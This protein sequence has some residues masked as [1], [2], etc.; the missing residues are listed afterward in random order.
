MSLLFRAMISLRISN[1]TLVDSR[2]SFSL[3]VYCLMSSWAVFHSDAMV[4]TSSLMVLMPST[5]SSPI[6]FAVIRDSAIAIEFALKNSA[7]A[8]SSAADKVEPERKSHTFPNG[9]DMNPPRFL[10]QVSM[11]RLFF[12]MISSTFASDFANSSIVAPPSLSL[13]ISS[14]ACCVRSM[15]PFHLS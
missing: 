8:L 9:P 7:L 2:Y 14:R 10:F 13:T 5:N 3:S 12:W 1:K 4:L 6:F 15:T 11:A